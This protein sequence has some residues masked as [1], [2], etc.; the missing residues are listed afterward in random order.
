MA[1][2]ASQRPRAFQGCCGAPVL[3]EKIDRYR[4]T[5]DTHE[6]VGEGVEPWA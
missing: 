1:L 3:D 6:R 4:A 5:Y 2:H